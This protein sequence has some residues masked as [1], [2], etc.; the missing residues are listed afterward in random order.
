MY[1][2]MVEFLFT[3]NMFITSDSTFLIPA[4]SSSS[5]SWA[6]ALFISSAADTW[7]H[8]ANLNNIKRTDFPEVT[9]KVLTKAHPL[10]KKKI[11][12]FP[13]KYSYQLM[14]NTFTLPGNTEPRS[15][16]QTYH[17][18]LFFFFMWVTAMF[19]TNNTRRCCTIAGRKKTR[20]QA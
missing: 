16:L 12:I 1:S 18:Y 14:I 2:Y 13:T 3:G 7:F 17:L 20:G 6:A 10:K 5:S 11:F 4:V 19:H 8:P 9:L 15:V